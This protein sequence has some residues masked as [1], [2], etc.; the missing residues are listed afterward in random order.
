MNILHITFSAN[1]HRSLAYI[2]SH[3]TADA[4]RLSQTFLEQPIYTYTHTNCPIRPSTAVRPGGR[5]NT[6]AIWYCWMVRVVLHS[7]KK[8]SDGLILMGELE[9]KK[10]ELNIFCQTRYGSMTGI[11]FVWTYQLHLLDIFFKGTDI[12]W[13]CLF[14]LRS[15]CISTAKT[16]EYL[17]YKTQS[18]TYY[19]YIKLTT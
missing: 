2:R 13:L 1:V 6:T 5:D 10:Y 12:A 17:I 16:H 18:L 11:T 15:N 9:K 8:V 19:M 3:K 14:T 7:A 4:A